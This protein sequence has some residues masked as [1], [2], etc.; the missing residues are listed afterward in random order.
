[1]HIITTV[2]STPTSITRECSCGWITIGTIP[3]PDYH[4]PLVQR[5]TDHLDEVAKLADG[6]V[7][8]E[9]PGRHSYE[10]FLRR[11]LRTGEPNEVVVR[12]VWLGGFREVLIWPWTAQ[13]LAEAQQWCD[14]HYTL[15]STTGFPVQPDSLARHIEA[16]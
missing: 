15:W 13:G 8:G 4:T 9:I 10:L 7:W 2:E 12:A 1:V 11:R 3:E 5:E 6:R 16:R 14:Q